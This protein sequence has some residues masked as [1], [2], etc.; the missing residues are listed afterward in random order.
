[1][2]KMLEKKKRE[3]RKRNLV[4][5][6]IKE[7]KGNYERIKKGIVKIGKTEWK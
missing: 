7:E 1:M 5:K 6:I 4:F 3:K 2:E